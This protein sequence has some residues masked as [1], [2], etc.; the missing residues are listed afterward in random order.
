MTENITQTAKFTA[1]A[2][3]LAASAEICSRLYPG[4]PASNV[5]D[6][7]FSLLAVRARTVF[8]HSIVRR[9]SPL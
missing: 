3:V 8:A 2:S 9:V 5:V 7:T 4:F 1:N 6:T